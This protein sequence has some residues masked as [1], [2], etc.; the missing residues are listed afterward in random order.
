[1]RRCCSSRTRQPCSHSPR[2]SRR[3]LC[4][5]WTCHPCLHLSFSSSKCYYCLLRPL[6]FPL[7]QH[8]IDGG[9]TAHLHCCFFSPQCLTCLTCVG[10]KRSTTRAPCR[11]QLGQPRP[12]FCPCWAG[13]WSACQTRQCAGYRSRSDTEG[14]CQRFQSLSFRL[15]SFS[16]LSCQRLFWPWM[17][18]GPSQP[19]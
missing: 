3:S 7:S 1:M 18:L 11:A 8:E 17:V 6:A 14:Q 10:S 13:T 9:L 19:S 16:N 4:C 15:L 2:S 12:F 5:W